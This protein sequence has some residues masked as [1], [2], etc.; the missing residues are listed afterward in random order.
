[1]KIGSQNQS[2]TPHHLEYRYYV[3]PPIIIALGSFSQ[4]QERSSARISLSTLEAITSPQ[5]WLKRL[6]EK[7]KTLKFQNIQNAPGT[8]NI[9]SRQI[10][11]VCLK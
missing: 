8:R 7:A 9:S 5:G 4:I 11:D 6:A 10:E 1:V 2:I 3:P